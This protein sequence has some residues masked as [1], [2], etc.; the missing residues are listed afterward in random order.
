MTYTFKL[1]RRI[2]RFRAPLVLAAAVAACGGDKPFDPTG[3]SGPAE[4]V[5]SAFAGGIPFGISAMPISEYGSRYNG[6]LLNLAPRTMLA[7]LAQIKSRGGKVIIKLAGHPRY[8]GEGEGFDLA[9]WK[10]RI[11]V[12]KGIDFAPYVR[13]GTIVGHYMIDEPNDPK[14][15]GGKPV[16]SATLE[17]M[18]RY[19]KQLWPEM[20]TIVRTEPSYLGYNHHY[21]DAA[22]AAY[23]DRKGP[24]QEFIRRNVSDAQARGLALVIGLNILDGGVPNLTQMTPSEAQ[25]WGSALLEST[26]PCAFMMWRYEGGVFSGSMGNAMDALSRLARNRSVRTCRRGAGGSTPQPP[27]SEPPP[28]DPEPSEP[29]PSSV[30][31]V[32]FGPYGLPLERMGAFGGSGRTVT[33]DNVLA[34]V[35]AARQSGNRIILR[36]AVD[37]VTNSDGTFNLTKWKAALDRYGRV[38]LSSFANDGTIAG[39]LLVQGPQN[40]RQWGGRAISHATLDE[41]ARYSRQRWA[42]IPTVVEAPAAWL[43][44]QS[45]WKHL[46]AVSATYAASDGDASRWVAGQASVARSAGLG[47]LVEMNVLNG[48][49]SSSGISGVTRGKYAMSASQVR[50]WGS[51]L[52]AQSH[53]CG[54]VL[55]RYDDRYF[56]RSDIRDALRDVGAKARSRTAKACRTS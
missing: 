16:P 31:G 3:D 46:D 11:D 10:R 1:A 24:P 32:P 40:A 6:A 55:A 33:P 28:S 21:V 41:M 27:P 25:S 4:P 43:A 52:L 13:D 35:R 44:R 2:A 9:A 51:T 19:S 26:Y 53:V 38:D 12:Y 18:G 5:A 15:W 48:G 23:L 37:G 54:L 30:T 14:N 36:M 42:A 22:W 34:T 8:Y 50:N 47:L 29:P 49:T 45:D 20:P 17:E 7:E 56:G 39:H